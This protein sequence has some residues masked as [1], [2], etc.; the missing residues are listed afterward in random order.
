[1]D[2]V[3]DQYGVDT[4][5]FFMASS[6]IVNGEDVR[7]SVDFLRDVQ[8][9]VFMTFNNVFSFYKLYADVDKWQPKNP[10]EEPKSTNILDQWMI[11]RLN[12][13]IIEVT[14]GME[15]Y[16]LDKAARPIGELLD[17]ISNWYVRRSR[18]VFGKLRMMLIKTKHTKLCIM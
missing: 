4:M 11:A 6:P 8:R 13:A 7:F 3:F 1:M 14:E 9:N 17:D 2:E 12:Q 10:L 18:R 15:E 16:R 5:R